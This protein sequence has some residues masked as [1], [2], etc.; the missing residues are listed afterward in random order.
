[1]NHLHTILGWSVIALF[2]ITAPVA[3]ALIVTGVR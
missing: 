3:L 2:T 1:M